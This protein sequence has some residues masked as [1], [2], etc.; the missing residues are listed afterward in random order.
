[1]DGQQQSRIDRAQGCLLGQ[2]AGDS[3]GSLVEFRTELDI[4]RDYPHGVGDLADG[5]TFN[6]LA[7]QPTD[8]SEM[9]LCDAQLVDLGRYDAKDVLASYRDWIESD[10]FDYGH[11]VST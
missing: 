6:T 3:L 9:A 7:G 11:T 10:P 5:R 8:E 1:M 4:L 2:L